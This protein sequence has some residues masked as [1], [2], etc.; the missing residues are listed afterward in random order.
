MRNEEC[1]GKPRKRKKGEKAAKKHP[2]EVATSGP[3]TTLPQRKEGKILGGKRDGKRRGAQKT[4]R[5]TEALS[6]KEQAL[7]CAITADR[8]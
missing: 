1:A 8:V 7:H 4:F 3:D 6:Q 5:S 2:E